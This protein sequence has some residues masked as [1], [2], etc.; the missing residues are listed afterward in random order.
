MAARAVLQQHLPSAATIQ[1][2]DL[3]KWCD[4]DDDDG[5]DGDDDDD[6]DD[7]DDNNNNNHS[8][9]LASFDARDVHA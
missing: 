1:S 2:A 4:D 8:Y 6:D 7:D 9:L 3:W 5:D